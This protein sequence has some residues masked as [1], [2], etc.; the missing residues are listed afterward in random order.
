MKTL[1]ISLV[2]A[3]EAIK[4]VPAL[5]E[6]LKKSEIWTHGRSTANDI[7]EMVWSGQTNLWVVFEVDTH[8]ICGHFIT[9]VKQYPQCKMLVVQNCAME[10]HTME[11]VEPKMQSIA[12]RFAKDFGCS[13]IEFVGRPGWKKHASKYGYDVQHVVYQKLF[14]ETS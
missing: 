9:E 6:Y 8:K 13:G 11:S 3:E 2:P 12:E 14:K 7:L 1:D 4:F 10:P 5:Q